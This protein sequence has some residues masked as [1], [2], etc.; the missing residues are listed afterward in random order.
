MTATASA[1]AN[2]R[3]RSA[4]VRASDVTAYPFTRTTDSSANNPS[5]RWVC[6][7]I[8]PLAARVTWTRS[9]ASGGTGKSW[10]AEADA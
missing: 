6:L 4:A 8:R 7:V 3:A 2:Q 1:Y 5:W 10:S 9:R